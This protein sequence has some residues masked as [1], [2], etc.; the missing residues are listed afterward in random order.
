MTLAAVARKAGVSTATVSYVL[1][2]VQLDRIPDATQTR[3][4][5]AALALGYVPN[6]SARALSVG[7]SNLVIA[8]IP[9]GSPM[10]QRAAA[11]LDRLGTYLREEGFTLLL[12]SDASLSGLAAAQQWSALRPSALITDSKLLGDAGIK[13]MRQ[14]GSTVI[15][16]DEQP[17]G[18]LPTL[19]MDHS[20]LGE[21]AAQ[22]MIDRGCRTLCMVM[23]DANLPAGLLERARGRLEG[24]RR[25]LRA[26]RA[27][28]VKLTVAEMTCNAR[29]AKRIVT[30]WVERGLPDGAIGFDDEYCGLLLGALTDANI[31]VPK[32]IALIGADDLPL[33]E[34]LR[35]RLTSVSLDLDSVKDSLAAPVIAAIRGEWTTG[36]RGEPWRASLHRR[37]T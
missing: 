33:C 18:E 9:G 26:S 19:A 34:M 6:A 20:A 27:R 28:R 15:A 23:P 1:N 7:R 31:E 5:D 37:D 2:G 3:V 32:D 16:L 8:H 36:T 30:D 12:H 29:A 17:V 24:V 21:V 4:R 13:L 25:A 22:H 14:V 10:L 35:P 11:G